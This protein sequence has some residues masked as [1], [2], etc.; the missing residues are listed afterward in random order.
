MIEIQLVGKEEFQNCSD[1]RERKT[2][3]EDGI[4]YRPNT[5]RS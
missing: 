4:G 5:L 3:T 2:P 1:P